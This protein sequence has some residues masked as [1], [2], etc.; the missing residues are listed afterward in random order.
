VQPQ[1]QRPTAKS[2][3][4]ANLKRSPQRAPPKHPTTKTDTIEDPI[5]RLAARL[6]RRCPAREAYRRRCLHMMASASPPPWACRRSPPSSRWPVVSTRRTQK[7][8]AAPENPTRSLTG[9]GSRAV[10]LLVLQSSCGFS[11]RGV[12]PFES[13]TSPVCVSC[14]WCLPRSMLSANELGVAAVVQVGVRGPPKG[15]HPVGFVCK[16]TCTSTDRP[17]AGPPCEWSVAR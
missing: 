16:V 10:R 4:G 7:V 6:A 15:A 8:P 14:T 17:T 13:A 9:P 5:C 12:T 1:D 3:Q 2:F 11:A